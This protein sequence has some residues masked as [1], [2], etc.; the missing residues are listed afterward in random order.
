[1]RMDFITLWILIDYETV[2]VHAKILAFVFILYCFSLQVHQL[3]HSSRTEVLLS[4]TITLSSLT[5]ERITKCL[6]LW[7]KHRHTHNGA[8]TCATTLAQIEKEK[9]NKMEQKQQEQQQQQQQ[10]RRWRR[11]QRD[12]FSKTIYNE[13]AQS[14]RKLKSMR[15]HS[16]RCICMIRWREKRVIIL[17]VCVATTYRML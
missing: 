11:R 5:T 17:L 12:V 9:K 16:S 13:R 8:E 4:R 3:N 2:F 1:M 10:L 7:A 6:L 15:P 14:G